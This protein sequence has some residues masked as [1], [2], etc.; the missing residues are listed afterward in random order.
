MSRACQKCRDIHPHGFHLCG[1]KLIS[2][3]CRHFYAFWVCLYLN[4]LWF[5][6]GI[7][8]WSTPTWSKTVLSFFSHLKTTNKVKQKPWNGILYICGMHAINKGSHSSKGDDLINVQNCTVCI[9][10]SL[11]DQ[12]RNNPGTLSPPSLHKYEML[13]NSNLQTGDLCS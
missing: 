4:I 11:K 5:T 1:S 6:Q 2:G 7:S 10:H 3:N 13:S 9:K 8:K 12:R